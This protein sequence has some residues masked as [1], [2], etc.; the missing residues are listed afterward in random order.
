MD[1]TPAEIWQYNSSEASPWLHFLTHREEYTM[2]LQ[3]LN[4][5]FYLN[6]I[7]EILG[8]GKT[9]IGLPWT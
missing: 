7:L 8:F 9:F 3:K 6:R 2:E 4:V 1:S 5:Y